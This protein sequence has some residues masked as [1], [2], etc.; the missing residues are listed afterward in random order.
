[1]THSPLTKAERQWWHDVEQALAI[2]TSAIMLQHNLM[3]LVTSDAL[4][5]RKAAAFEVANTI[6]AIARVA[7]SAR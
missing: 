1:M 6:A 3:V 2:V 5:T 7:V 4:E